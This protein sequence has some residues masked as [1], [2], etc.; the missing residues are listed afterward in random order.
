LFAALLILVVVVFFS[1]LLRSLP[2]P[3]LAAIVI[4]AVTGLVK[5]DALKHL[6]RFSHSEFAVSMAALVGVLGSG[7]LRGVLIGVV[8]SILMLLRRSS[9]VFTT[10]LARVP[11]TN[12]FGDAFRHPENHREADVFIFRVEG[13]LLY[14]NVDHVRD[15]FF[16]LLSRRDRS[17]RLA[18]FYLGMVPMVDLAGAELLGEL[19][20]ALRQREIQFKLAEAHGQV[21]EALRRSGFT[22]SYGPVQ[23]NQTVASIVSQFVDAAGPQREMAL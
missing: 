21:R 11:G 18:V 1:D 2:Q 10:E 14:Y 9:R 4:A 13:A 19:D 17:I 16:E 3:V 20:R 22:E 23:A 5:V 8:L 7:I 15:R 6:W 12:I